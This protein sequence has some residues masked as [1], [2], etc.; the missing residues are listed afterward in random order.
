MTTVEDILEDI[1]E[2][3]KDIVSILKSFTIFEKEVINRIK[4]I[5]D[6]LRLVE[7]KPNAVTTFVTTADDWQKRVVP[8]KIKKRKFKRKIKPETIKKMFLKK[9]YH[10]SDDALSLIKDDPKKILIDIE[11]QR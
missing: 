6:S 7:V 9:G 11:K 3:N 2:I 10:I 8:C 4:N 5:E 1:V